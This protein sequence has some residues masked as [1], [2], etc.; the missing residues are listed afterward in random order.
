MH[1]GRFPRLFPECRRDTRFR[2]RAWQR[3]L[4]ALVHDTSGDE[5]RP[6]IPFIP[7]T[8]MSDVSEPETDFGS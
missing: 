4:D 7:T 2:F 3:S 8:S 5:G 6:S 1:M